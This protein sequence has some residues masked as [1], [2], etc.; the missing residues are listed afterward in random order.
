MVDVN[1]DALKGKEMQHWNVVAS[2]YILKN[3]SNLNANG[4]MPFFSIVYVDENIQIFAGL[5]D[6]N[7]W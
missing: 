5:K 2:G 4:W 1:K 7:G 6:N 3:Y